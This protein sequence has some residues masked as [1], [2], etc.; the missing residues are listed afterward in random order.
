MGKGRHIHGNVQRK[1]MRGDALG[2]ADPDKGDFRWT[3]APDPYPRQALAAM[4]VNAPLGQGGDENVLQ[5]MDV[6]LG[7]RAVIREPK[8]WI[9]DHLTWSMV[10][11]GPA[12]LC[13]ND[14]D[15]GLLGELFL[16][17]P[18]AALS[19]ATGCKHGLMFHEQEQITAI[20]GSSLGSTGAL[21]TPSLFVRKTPAEEQCR[22]LRHP[23]SFRMP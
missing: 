9:S 22:G 14:G 7:S 12:P 1:A 2:N 23:N 10:R 15:A 19:R 3:L 16:A 13:P 5:P 20:V 21:Q 11:D 17:R 6:R 4:A 18:M 8:D